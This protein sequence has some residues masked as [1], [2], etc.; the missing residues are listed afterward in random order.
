MLLQLNLGLLFPNKFVTKKIS[1]IDFNSLRL[2]LSLGVALLSAIGLGSVAVWMSWRMQEI[3]VMNH[4]KTASSVVERFPRDV[5]IYSQMLP[6]E[7]G[8]QKTIDNLSTENTIFWVKNPQQKIIAQSYNLSEQILTKK[9]IPL[10]PKI[11]LIDNQ[12]WLLCGSTLNINNQLVGKLYLAQN[13]TKDQILFV[14][15]IKS[16]SIAT[17]I[18]V[19]LI[20][21][22]SIFYIRQSLKPLEKINH[23]AENISAEQLKQVSINLQ[24]A[25][26]EV[27]QLAETL[28]KMLLRL[29]ESWE[30]QQQLLSNVSHEL[31]TPLTI[32]SGYLQSTLRRGDNL[33]DIQKEALTT[34]SEEANRTVQL[35]SDLLDLAR[36]DSG[37]IML[38]LEVIIVEELLTEII[39]MAK[40]YSDRNIRLNIENP[41]LKIKVD[42]NRFKQI[43]LNLIDN[44]I[45]YS[46]KNT[47]IN[48]NL[49]EKNGVII[50]FE[51]Q[52][53]GIPLAQQNRIF[54]RFY[55]VDEARTRSTG[56][57]GLGLAIVK[58]LVNSMNGDIS[59]RSQPEQGSIFMVK[60]PVQ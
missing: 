60:F 5:E 22:A 57:T 15:L 9:D 12:Y 11:S 29:G 3:L 14:S 35:L 44:A 10:M 17:L 51:D 45:K 16:L 27:K 8:I 20:I 30:H 1:L 21:L 24:N 6:L 19:T 55:R 46:E 7:I 4:K 39:G 28:D 43:C 33:T 32:V 41:Q 42:R 59:L 26:S 13:I 31:R 34:A 52:G 36:A 40:Q 37:I 56:G 50:E 54:E 47:A 25:P 2:R 53:I 23:T 18:A 58:T 48:I 38:N 49:K